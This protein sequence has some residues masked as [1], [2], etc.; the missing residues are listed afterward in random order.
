VSVNGNDLNTCNVPT[1]PCRTYTGAISQT[2][3]GGVVIVMDSGTFG[4]ATI[5][6]SVTIDAPAGVVALSA[7]PIIV[8]AVQVVLRG[9]TFQAPVPGS[10]TAIT[11]QGGALFVENVVVDGW[12][13]GLV[14]SDFAGGLYVKGSVFRNQANYGLQV[15]FGNQGS[16]AID[17]SF[18]ERN[19]VGLLLA[20]GKGRVSNTVISA[21]NSGGWVQEMG[22]FTFHR[23]RVFG[24]SILGLYAVLNATLRVSQSTITRNA[25]GLQNGGSGAVVES[26]SNNA[27]LGN[28]TETSGTVTPVVLQ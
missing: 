6:Q 22:E 1:T 5:T 14:S 3:P 7:T 13:V 20:G 18:F 26:F 2:T 16:V 27:I 8:N 17:G 21:N 4:G 19:A 28:T 12:S 15:Q 24:N 10:G 9:L 25:T 11:H 23:C